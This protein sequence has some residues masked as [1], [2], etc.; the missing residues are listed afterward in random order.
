MGPVPYIIKH[1]TAVIT[2]IVQEDSAFA[3]SC[4]FLLALTNTLAFYVTKLIMAVISFMIQ[5]P[6]PNVIKLFMLVIYKF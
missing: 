4:H 2:S 6:G 3:I 5:T 1:I